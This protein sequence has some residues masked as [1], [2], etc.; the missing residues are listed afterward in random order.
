MNPIFSY[1][2][3]FNLLNC[4]NEKTSKIKIV[5][6]VWNYRDKFINVYFTILECKISILDIL[7]FCWI[8]FFYLCFCI[9]HSFLLL[10]LNYFQYL[11]QTFYY[12]RKLS[13][14]N[15]NNGMEWDCKKICTTLSLFLNFI[16]NLIFHINIFTEH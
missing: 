12:Y 1:Y 14:N 7:F 16:W 9:K 15:C 11:L 13:N 3:N 10:F 8:Y 4:F 6:I 5:K 2:F